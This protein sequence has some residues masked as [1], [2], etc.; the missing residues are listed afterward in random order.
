MKKTIKMMLLGGAVVLL[1]GCASNCTTISSFGNDGTDVGAGFGGTVGVSTSSS[2]LAGDLING[3]VQFTNKTSSAQNFQYK[4]EWF[5]T[6]GFSQ[7]EN[8]P[9]QPLQL[10]PHMSRVVSAVA[11]N[12]NATKFKVLVCQK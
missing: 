3:K 7:G 2:R 9:W 10:Y 6:D 4:F 12:T 5:T 1:A 11:P 8:T